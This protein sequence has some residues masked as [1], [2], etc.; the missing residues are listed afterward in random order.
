MQV[1]LGMFVE[2]LGVDLAED[3]AEVEVGVGDVLDLLA[4]DV[5]DIPLFTAGHNRSSPTKHQ[6]IVHRVKPRRLAG[7][8][9]GGSEGPEGEAVAVQGSVGE[10]DGLAE[11]AEDDGMLARVVADPEGVDAD[12]A[13][14]PFAGLAA[15]GRDIFQGAD[16]RID[17][18]GEPQRR[19]ARGVLLESMVP[20]DDLDVGP[21]PE[22]LGRLGDEPEKEVDA[23]AE[24]RRD[25]QR[26]PVGERFETPTSPGL[27]PGRADDERDAEI[28]A[29][30]AMARLAAGVEKSMTTDAGAR[31]PNPI[32]RSNREVP[33]AP[34]PGMAGADRAPRP[35]SSQGH[36]R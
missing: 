11:E 16:R 31:G 8:E 12:L 27:E 21:V 4:A 29:N 2:D 3:V 32:G 7:E 35:G 33:P 36:P 13:P 25:Q 6:Q 26:D 17:G 24:I 20:L 1:P 5:A 14:G 30:L 15:A 23:L 34:D 9:L 28:D 22:R 19:P 10:F 18:L